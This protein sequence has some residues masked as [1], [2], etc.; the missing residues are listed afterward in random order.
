MNIQRAHRYLL[1]L[2]AYLDVEVIRGVE[3]SY[4]NED[5]VITEVF[6]GKVTKGWIFSMLHEL[7]HVILESRHDYA[8]THWKLAK[9]GHQAVDMVS[10]VQIMQEELLAWQEGWKL[11]EKIGIEITQKDYDTFAAKYAMRYMK[12]L[13]EPYRNE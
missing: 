7:G 6:R 9:S 5:R 1:E 4:N 10:S 13:S 12:V 8:K 2:C 11:A 3:W